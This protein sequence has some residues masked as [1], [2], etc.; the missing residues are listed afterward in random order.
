M[1]RR[2]CFGFCPALITAAIPLR[3]ANK[4]HAGEAS[5]TIKVWTNDD[6]EKLRHP[7]CHLLNHEDKGM[8]AKILFE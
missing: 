4:P 7:G 1:A 8:M 5:Q 6:L 2:S 3:A